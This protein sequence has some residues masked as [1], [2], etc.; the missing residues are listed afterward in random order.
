MSIRKQKLNNNDIY[1]IYNRGVD[2]R[3]IFCDK[4]DFQRFL[5]IMEEFNAVDSIGGVYVHSLK[6]NQTRKMKSIKLV[7]IITYCLNPN[8]YHLILKQVADNGISKF[9]QK[10]GTG[11]TMYFNKKYKRNGVLFQGRF[12]SHIAE[13][14]DKLLKLSVYVNLN[15]KVHGLKRFGDSAFEFIKSSWGEYIEGIGNG[16]NFCEK[17]V[18]L[19]EF[20]NKKEYEKFAQKKIREIIKERKDMKNVEALKNVEARPL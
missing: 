18:I 8:H 4:S 11:Y 10:V 20:K 19:K 14:G 16:N 6:K 13:K 12:K 17:D 5:K 7:N 1:H 9:M 2:K 15:F 3:M